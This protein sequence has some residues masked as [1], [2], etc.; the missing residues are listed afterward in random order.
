[1][2]DW[3]LIT[4]EY[5][6]ALGGVGDY[7]RLVA[8]GLAG[9]GACVHVWCPPAQRSRP[10]AP[11]VTLHPTLGDFGRAA[12]AETGRQLD[13]FAGPRR[14]FVQWVPHGYGWRSMNLPFCRWVRG[15]TRRGDVVDLMV[16]EP[17]LR[18]GG[19][20]RQYL[21]AAVH[22]VMAAV[23]LRAARRVW[24]STPAWESYLRPYAPRGL[25]LRWLP[26]FST[27]PAGGAGGRDVRRR[28]APGGPLVG[29][30]G[31]AGPAVNPLLTD[32]LHRIL[33]GRPD[34]SALLL[35]RGSERIREQLLAAAGDLAERVHA[36]GALPLD[37][38]PDHLAACDLLLQPLPEGLTTRSTGVMAGLAN[39][40]PVVTTAGPLTEPL[41]SETRAVY[42]TKLDAEALASAAL[43]LL[44]RP[45]ERDRLA[46][47]G[48]D[49]Y[50]KRFAMR[51][52]LDALCASEVGEDVAVGP[53]S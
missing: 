4:C 40:R 51:H 5:P 6:P 52:T 42:L 46:Q 34:A 21:A 50:E 37:E 19:S 3:H 47:A 28:L 39:G 2:S 7:C 15:R 20:C 8:E 14:L 27:V 33:R 26:V 9:A 32:T 1:M 16:H 23:L 12:L 45:P 10:S 48:L 41:W 24:L 18:F 49:L 17:F 43:G 13:R 36:T 38:V 11:G 25:A 30:F 53:L 29:R 31:S 35:G 44:E 22:R